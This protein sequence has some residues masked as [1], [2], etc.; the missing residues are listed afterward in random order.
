MSFTVPWGS[1]ILRTANLVAVE[2]FLGYF[3]TASVFA[4]YSTGHRYHG[5]KKK[6]GF[7][8]PSSNVAVVKKTRAMTE[9]VRGKQR[10]TLLA[11]LYVL[12]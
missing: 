8:A 3:C 5:V 1:V 10:Y 2:D 4:L 12:K 9:G 6:K 7:R 11:L